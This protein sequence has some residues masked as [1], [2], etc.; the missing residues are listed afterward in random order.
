[1]SP[2][3]PQLSPTTSQT[4]S[5]GAGRN[6]SDRPRSNTRRV[7]AACARYN[8]LAVDLSSADQPRGTP[9]VPVG[10]SEPTTRGAPCRASLAA[11]IAMPTG[12]STT[13]TVNE[14]R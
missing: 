4:R 8:A 1:M 6:T 7:P 9:G 12:A 3:G 5:G 2:P 10:T 11:M 14:G 13:I